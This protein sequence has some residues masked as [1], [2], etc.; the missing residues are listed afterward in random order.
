MDQKQNKYLS[1]SY[2]LY[3]IEDDGK[4]SLVEQTQQ[5][6]P[7]QFISGFG[8]SL[9]AFEQHI[10]DLQPGEKFDFT[11]A[12]AEAFGEYEENGV[13]KLDRE[14][15]CIEG[16]FD[17]TNVYPGAVITLMD[18]DEKRFM[19]RV[20]EVEDDGVTVDTNH[21]LAGE[22][23][24]FTGVVLEN[25]EATTDEIQRMLQSLSCEQCSCD[26]CENTHEGG[27]GGCGHCGH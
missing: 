10:V 14:M 5:G 15:F 2:Q 16:K 23:L 9:D 11:V 6:K 8:V 7:F 17:H 4:K 12:P 20:A 3:T 18:Q 1:V 19:A 24:N 27:C 22:T 25:R 21:P 26:D 13:H